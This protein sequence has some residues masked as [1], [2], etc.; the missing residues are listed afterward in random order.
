[1]A[2]YSAVG[3]KRKKIC[4]QVNISED[5]GK[6]TREVVDAIRHRAYEIFVAQ[7]C[8]SG[9]ELNHWL[10]AESELLSPLHLDIEDQAN[11]LIVKG[12]LPGFSQGEFELK[13]E[14]RLL[15]IAGKREQPNG[16]EG[17]NTPSNSLNAHWIFMTLVLP[18]TVQCEYAAALL[19]G[20]TLEVILPKMPKS[21]ELTSS[22]P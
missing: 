10:Q 21:S 15:T 20:R 3:T 7:G 22:A 4:E 8:K 16:R 2:G 13:V 5:L 12:D 19:T 1:M 9:S 17:K 6:R 14:P 18:E 11:A